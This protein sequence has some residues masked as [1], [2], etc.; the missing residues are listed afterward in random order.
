MS[1]KLNWTRETNLRNPDLSR[2]DTGPATESA[3]RS[4]KD[5]DYKNPYITLPDGAIA[6]ANTVIDARVPIESVCLPGRQDLDAKMKKKNTSYRIKKADK[7]IEIG[8]VKEPII[9]GTLWSKKINAELEKISDMIPN[10]PMILCVMATVGGGKSTILH[11]LLPA[12]AHPDRF[13]QVRIYSSSMGQDPIT[14]TMMANRH[15]DVD[16]ECAT[17]PNFNFIYSKAD[18]VRLH[19]ANEAEM[20]KNGYFKKPVSKL[21][22][23][24]VK[25]LQPFDSLTHPHTNEDGSRHGRIPRVPNFRSDWHTKP[26]LLSVICGEQPVEYELAKSMPV[27]DAGIQPRQSRIHTLKPVNFTDLNP[28]QHVRD[29]NLKD[30]T[31]MEQQRRMRIASEARARPFDYK[32]VHEPTPCLFIFED[33]A[34]MFHGPGSTQ[35]NAWLSTIRHS[36][37]AVIF[38]FQQKTAV[39][40][41]LRTVATHAIIMRCNN[42]LELQ[43]LEDEWGGTITDFLGKYHAATTPID[44]RDRDFLYVDLRK[45][46]CAYR[47]LYGSLENAEE[48]TAQSE[49]RDKQPSVSQT[50]STN[51]PTQPEKGTRKKPSKC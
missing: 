38:I 15:P 5:F 22:D 9:D 24:I 23:R 16:I 37:C 40:R 34:Y 48:V 42:G 25:S 10:M 35:F 45:E 17:E 28:M 14:M 19:Y 12:Y 7:P 43:S 20:A 32:V 33:C 47:S 18:E 51:P 49:E 39:P 31:T 44:G 30:T 2:V 8:P 6:H 21:H 11:T 13:P 41:F 46:N 1:F 36:H 26:K 27:A 4:R 50:S 3:K 29:L